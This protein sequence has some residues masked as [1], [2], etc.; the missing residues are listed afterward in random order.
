MK[1]R[2]R[3]L[4]LLLVGVST[5]LFTS[6]AAELSGRHRKWLEE[7][8]VYIITPT[9]RDVFLELGTDRERE[10]FI[11]AFWKHRDPTP[12]SPENE[13]RSEHYRRLEYADRRLGREAPV[14]GWKTDRGRM[15]ILLGEPQEIRR[16]T[17]KTEICDCEMWFYQGKSGLDLPT[18]FYLLFYKERGVGAF[19]LYSPGRDG[20]QALLTGYGGGAGDYRKA[21]EIL[22]DVD[23]SLAEVAWNLIPG[24]SGGGLGRPSMAS[25]TLLQRIETLPRRTVSE[26]Y[27]RRFLEYKDRVEVEYTAN[28]MDSDSLVRVFREPNGLYFVHYA[29]QPKRLSVNQYENKFYTT[30]TVNGRVT[31]LDGRPVYQ[32]DATI[33]VEI[34]ADRIQ[35]LSGSPFEYTD[36]FPLVGGDY[37]VSVLIK[38]EVSK[39][40][41]SFERAV[42]VPGGNEGPQLTQPVL[43]YEAVRPGLSERRVKAFRVGPFQVFCRP[44]RI[45]T[46][47]D[48]LAVAFQLNN[49]QAEAVRNG[50][51]R[52]AFLKD[53]EPFREIARKPSDYADLPDVLEEI[54]LADFPPAHYTIRVSLLE[55]GEEAVSA[56]EE[57]DLTF[58]RAVPRPWFSS[59]TLP[60][61]DDPIYD[62]IRAGQLH[63]AGG[64]D[65]ALEFQERAFFRQPEDQDVA[66]NLAK[67]CLALGRLPRAVQVLGPFLESDETPKYELCLLAGEAFGKSGN[68]GR[69]AEVLNRALA[70]YGVNAGLLNALGESYLGLGDDREALAAFERSLRLSPGQPEIVGKVAD[71][72]K[73]K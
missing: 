32:F 29:V 33:P 22:R 52:I 28:Y 11:E 67:I 63:N 71:L 55:S 20:P 72:K 18:G 13:F 27:A 69:A 39:E 2:L 4:T 8:V 23:D 64:H 42:R 30:L 73:K 36:V 25:D 31:S 49:L 3:L 60:G 57:F 46:S 19:R 41:T 44:D 1:R 38:N 16:Y 58:A 7:E 37:K 40:F 26:T 47:S 65:E 70:R 45:F 62:Q 5:Q 54:G 9:E 53:G 15:Y 59:R 12:A 66:I 48:T 35:G 14:A 56:S 21:Y 34:G 10:L 17:G 24:E 50:E 51:V 6:S 68:F 61:A 43:G